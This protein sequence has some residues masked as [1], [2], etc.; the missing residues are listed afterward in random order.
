MLYSQ[1]GI[2]NVLDDW[3]AGPMKANDNSSS[4]AKKNALALQA[5][6]N[7]AQA[8]CA[9]SPPGGPM[10]GAIIL[11]PSND[12]YED[13]GTYSIQGPPGAPVAVVVSCYYPIRILVPGVQRVPV[14]DPSG[15]RP[16]PR[17]P[18]PQAG[19][20]VEKVLKVRPR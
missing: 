4:R 10:Y 15:T 9:S 3:G 2:F 5:T 12:M 16:R 17:A 18:E 1:P 7:A 13:G 19:W 14:F 6:I 8:Y 20:P 11:I